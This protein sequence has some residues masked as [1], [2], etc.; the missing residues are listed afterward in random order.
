MLDSSH[1]LEIAGHGIVS[2]EDV[3][4]CVRKTVEHLPSNIVEIVR[5]RI[6]LKPRAEVTLGTDL[7]VGE[8][9]EHFRTY[10]NQFL[11]RKQLHNA[12]D[13]VARQRALNRMDLRFAPR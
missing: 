1:G 4:Y 9:I 10:G 13:T 2:Q 11:I 8:R 5:R 3:A 6:W 12:S 7:A